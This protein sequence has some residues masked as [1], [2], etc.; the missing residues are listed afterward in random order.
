[1]QLKDWL[2]QTVLALIPMIRSLWVAAFAINKFSAVCCEVAFE[3]HDDVT[4]STYPFIPV[5]ALV[6]EV[7]TVLILLDTVLSTYPRIPILALVIEVLT[8]LILLD[9]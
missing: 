4:A 5:F 8:V 7:L 3:V 2:R 6:I 1:M 9:M